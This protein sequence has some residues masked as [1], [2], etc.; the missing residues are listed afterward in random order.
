[1]LIQKGT[2]MLITHPHEVLA[3]LKEQRALLLIL[4]KIMD[5]IVSDEERKILKLLSNGPLHIEQLLRKSGMKPSAV[6]VIL[7]TLSLKGLVV[8]EQ[9]IYRIKPG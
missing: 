7:T 1:M 4:E 2:A 6:M 5:D 3:T 9:S 8:E